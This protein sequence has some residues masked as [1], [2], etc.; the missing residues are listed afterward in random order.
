MLEFHS[1]PAT[2]AQLAVATAAV[3]AAPQLAVAGSDS[4]PVLLVLC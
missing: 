3:A 4:Q 1:S 2:F